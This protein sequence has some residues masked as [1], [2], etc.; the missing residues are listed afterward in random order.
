MKKNDVYT[1]EITGMSH[2][3]QGV[4]K[5]DNFAVFIDGALLGEVVN[6]KIIKVNKSYAIGKLIEIIKPSKDRAEPFCNDYKRCGGCSL[7]H[8]NYNAQLNFKTDTVREN[9][10]RIGKLEG[11]FVHDIIGM[12]TAMYY[13]NKAQYPVGINKEGISIGFYAP[14]SHDIVNND[15][16]HIQNQTSDV[17]KCVVKEFIEENKISVYDELSGKGLVRHVI[18]RVGF[19]TKEVMVVLVIN[20]NDL[21]FIDR[22]V[23]KIT[24]KIPEV[25]SII[26]NINKKDTNV[27]LGNKNKVIFGQPKIV[28]YIGKYKFEISPLSFYQVNPIQTE[29]LYSKALEYADLTGNETVFDLYCGIGTISLFLSEKAKKVY[30]VEVVEDAIK[31]AKRNAEINNVENVEFLVG[32]AE[33]VV[34]K[35][36][37]QGVK[38]DVVVVDPPRKGCDELLLKTLVDMKPKRIVYVSCNPST[39]ARDL[40]YLDENGYRTVEVQ[41][42]DMFPHTGHVETVVL[43]SREDK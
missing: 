35:I 38:A 27:I 3:G 37:E 7:Q 39:L 20:G 21:P 9:I 23:E 5:I 30:G 16:C 14:R 32:G 33:N 40:K 29:V 22:L 31:D 42:V 18:T 10:K 4:G 12:E 43:M 15:A 8:L 2:E 34:P 13:R 25:K 17:V 24:K 36:Y 6:I 1:V 11:V 28:D 41:P 19:R 26:L